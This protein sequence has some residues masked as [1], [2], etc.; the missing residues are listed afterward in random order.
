[1]QSRVI[2]D[3]IVET[4]ELLLGRYRILRF[5]GGGKQGLVYAAS[6]QEDGL[7]DTGAV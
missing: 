4:D 7:V 5:I 6:D 3:R 1:M 2:F